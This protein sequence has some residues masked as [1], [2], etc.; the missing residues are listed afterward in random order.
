MSTRRDDER[1]ENANMSAAQAKGKRMSLPAANADVTALDT[2][3][4]RIST[5]GLGCMDEWRAMND[6]PKLFASGKACQT[7]SSDLRT[8]TFVRL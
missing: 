7:L 8:Q 2:P 5:R 4:G 6:G 3:V 1:I